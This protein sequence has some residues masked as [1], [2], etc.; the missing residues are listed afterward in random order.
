MLRGLAKRGYRAVMGTAVTEDP[1]RAWKGTA[2]GDLPRL[3][4]M[5][6]GDCSIRA[7]EN[8][9]D[10]KA[11]IG[12]PKVMAERLLDAGVGTEF[13]HYF[14]ITY[15]YLPDIEQLEKVTKMSGA[16][17][18]IL[19][20]TAATYTRR[21]ILNSTHRVNQLRVE[22]GRRLGRAIR[23]PYRMLLKPLV[24]LFGRHWNPYDGTELLE[25]F[26]DRVQAR[27]PNATVVMVPPL[28]FG[29]TY[30][31]SWAILD[32]VMEDCRAVAERRGLPFVHFTTLGDDKRLRCA[33]GYNLNM[34][35]SEIVGEELARW[36]LA[37]Q[38]RPAV[39]QRVA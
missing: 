11:P 8:S 6:V 36:I 28:P 19:V 25:Q 26:L 13:A 20:H 33:N 18:V 15:E 38:A 31:T 7:M 27:W 39:E 21:V 12:Y 14:A 32:R 22:T 4:V 9:H 10:P 30:P 1:V 23:L 29:W 17:D 5:H 16:P 3:R 2:G 24:R 34:R 35:G 37:E